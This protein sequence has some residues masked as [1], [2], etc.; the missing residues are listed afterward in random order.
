MRASIRELATISENRNENNTYNIIH[1]F[2]S[3]TIFP[4]NGNLFA[5]Q[6]GS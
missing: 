6:I 2:F 5:K 3:V 4:E 1:N